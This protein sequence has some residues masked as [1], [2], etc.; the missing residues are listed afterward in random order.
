MAQGRS[1]KVISII[2]GIRTS[3]L[4][5]KNSL[6]EHMC[7]PLFQHPSHCQPP[8]LARETTRLFDT[9]TRRHPSLCANSSLGDAP[10]AYNPLHNIH[11]RPHATLTPASTLSRQRRPATARC[12]HVS[13]SPRTSRIPLRICAAPEPG[14]QSLCVPPPRRAG[15]PQRII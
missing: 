10:F 15:S 9:L 3:S 4:S 1:T 12:P 2:K 8:R 11:P 5:M 6:F 13:P 7:T 14:L